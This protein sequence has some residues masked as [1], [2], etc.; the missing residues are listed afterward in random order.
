LR[1]NRYIYLFGILNNHQNLI[2]LVLI[3]KQYSMESVKSLKSLESLPEATYVLDDLM[4]RVFNAEQKLIDHKKQNLEII[5]I[6]IKN[7]SI[8]Q[9][10]LSGVYG[11]DKDSINNKNKLADHL[12]E[13][14]ELNLN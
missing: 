14:L 10:Q 2:E 6:L 13:L 7:I 11:L 4:E 1:K 5:K 12:V 9:I 3:N 8:I